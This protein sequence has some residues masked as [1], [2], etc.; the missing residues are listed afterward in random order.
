MIRFPLVRLG[1]MVVWVCAG[2]SVLNATTYYVDPAGSD[3]NTGTGPAQAWQTLQKAMGPDVKAGDQVLFKRGGEWRGQL[4][5]PQSSV[6][7]GAYG[8]GSKPVINSSRVVSG[9]TRHSGSIYKAVVPFEV[10]AVYRDGEFQELASWPNDTW[11]S[12][13]EASTANDHIIDADLVVPHDVV[14]AGVVIRSFDWFIQNS[15]VT[16]LSG[17]RINLVAKDYVPTEKSIYYF[18][19]KLWMLDLPG[20]WYYDLPTQT[21]YVW[22]DTGDSPASHRIEVSELDDGMLITG[23]SNV[24]V[25]NIA[26]VQSRLHG[27]RLNGTNR[28]ITLKGLEVTSARTHGIYT[29]NQISDSVIE[30]CV[31]SKCSGTGIRF[32]GTTN[33]S[34]RNNVVRDIGMEGSRS[35]MHSTAAIYVSGGSKGTVV[36]GNRVSHASYIGIRSDSDTIIR[37]NVVD[38]TMLRENDG[39]GIYVWGEKVTGC[40]IVGNIVTNVMGNPRPGG[41]PWAHG[42]YLDDKSNGVTL[43]GNTVVNAVAGMHLHNTYNDVITGNTIYQAR[44]CS[45]VVQE[46]RIVNIPGYIHD[47]T[48]QDNVFIGSAVG[49]P[50]VRLWGSLG[51]IAFG[52]FDNNRYLNVPGPLVGRV[53]L[54]G[55]EHALLFDQWKA[56]TGQD[57][58]SVDVGLYFRY[59]LFSAEHEGPNLITN[60]TFDSDINGWSRWSSGGLTTINWE[61]AG[62]MDGG[63]IR[64]VNG[65]TAGVDGQT[66]SNTFPIEQ[67]VTYCLTAE[68]VAPVLTPVKLVV[69]LNTHPYETYGSVDCFVTPERKT[70]RMYFT[71]PKDVSNARFN[72]HVKGPAEFLMDN[73]LL[74]RASVTVNDPATATRLLIND[75]PMPRVMTLGDGVYCNIEGLPVS[76]SVVLGPYASMVLLRSYAN[77][78]CDCNNW[79][80]STTAPEE[81]ASGQRGN[82]YGSVPSDSVAPTKPA[83]VVWN[84]VSADAIALSWTPSTDP[85]TS[86]GQ[87]PSTSSG[88]VLPGGSGL[89][90]YRIY[91]NGVEV[92]ISP[93]TSYRDA[94]L[95]A[96]TPY[97]YRVAAFDVAGN[98]SELSGPVTAT[99]LPASSNHAPQLSS[100]G[101]R[102]LQIGQPVQFTVEATD[103]DGDILDY[104]ASGG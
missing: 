90:G 46:D 21:L 28:A 29:E 55:S 41:G 48:I 39:G 64:T 47:L 60:S 9:W 14:G 38:Q 87:A 78:D 63:S 83:N 100:V 79:E 85:S 52:S 91:R 72:T 68:L 3:L 56:F 80:T 26:F 53:S 19:N 51:S 70:Y 36:S 102:I 77:G 101:S 7:Y 71:A 95:S 74:T 31:I 89:M 5:V 40:Q 97:T 20:E 11:L 24:T 58:Q 62:G 61:P 17:S 22:M 1:V 76:G 30:D 33:C 82:N 81:C 10:K 99:T 42:L 103:A 94:G 96:A 25:E 67:G 75:Q 88:Q 8:T 4:V 98:Q 34:I 73:V 43:T 18:N 27:V 37:N 49:E 6:V 32:N 16:S 59:E 23:R 13:S 12:V 86:S 66:I 54:P 2:F 44:Y 57:P 93:T 84:A 35:T 104:R 92:G 69:R 15:T 50:L 45:F 65:D